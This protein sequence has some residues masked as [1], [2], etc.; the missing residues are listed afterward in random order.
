M[1][2]IQNFVSSF[3]IYANK[4][5]LW[6]WIK[7]TAYDHY[8]GI[9]PRFYKLSKGQTSFVDLSNDMDCILSSMKSN[10]RNEI[11]RAI[12]EGCSFVVNKDYDCFIPFYN[13]FCKMKGLDKQTTK[14]ELLRF[15]DVII[16]IAM[17][18][19]T[20]LAMHATVID[21]EASVAMLLYSCSARL[22]NCVDKK[23]IGWGN[24]YL[25]FKDFEYFKSMGL[26][27]YDWNGV[28]TD[29]SQPEKF[30]IGQFKMAFGGYLVDNIKMDSPARI[31]AV[32]ILS[33]FH[34]K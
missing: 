18:N 6:D 2:V 19:Q 27:R 3:K 30:N 34:I 10:T 20:T 5:S 1:I 32:K 17:H 8:E 26:K 14:E 12:K 11:R 23:M 9:I 28:C 15:N 29:E 24:R 7:P 25:H 21:K 13:E 4:V 22:D 31:I 16:T 33:L